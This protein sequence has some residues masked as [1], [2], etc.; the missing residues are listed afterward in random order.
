MLLWSSFPIITQKLAM[1]SIKA[2]VGEELTKSV[3][4]L[5]LVGI[6]PGTSLVY[7]DVFMTEMTW[8]VFA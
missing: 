5:P 1:F 7:C 4:K 2:Y 6:E 3:R 8:Q